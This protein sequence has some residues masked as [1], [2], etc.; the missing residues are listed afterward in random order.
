MIDDDAS[1]PKKGIMTVINK[2]NENLSFVGMETNEA[3]Y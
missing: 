1:N 3:L 2:M